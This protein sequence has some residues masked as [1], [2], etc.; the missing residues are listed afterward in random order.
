MS[1]LSSAQSVFDA[2]IPDVTSPDF[3][4]YTGVEE[5]V[6]SSE[7]GKKGGPEPSTEFDGIASPEAITEEERISVS[8]ALGLDKISDFKQY[9]D[10]IFRIIEWAKS[11]GSSRISD[12]LARINEM[13]NQVGNSKSIYNLSVYAGMQLE[14]LRLERNLARFKK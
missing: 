5:K 2:Q 11:D 9:Q 1:G 3:M 4:N 6:D 8:K 7:I 14:Q 12:I 13:Q 10:Q